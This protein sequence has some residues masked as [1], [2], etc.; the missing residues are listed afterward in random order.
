MKTHIKKRG[1]EIEHIGILETKS[2]QAGGSE[3][4]EETDIAS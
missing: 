1:L 4:F 3:T 2:I